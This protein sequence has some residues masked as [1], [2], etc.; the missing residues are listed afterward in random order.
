MEEVEQICS[1]IAIMDKGKVIAT[2]TTSELKGMIK[3]GEKITAELLRADTGSL[4]GLRQLAG[5]ASAEIV[6][7]KLIVKSE[8]GKNNLP[9][10][11]DYLNTHGVAYGKIYCELPTLNDVFL[12]ITGK[13]LRD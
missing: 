4:T 2:G 9:A 12:E 11:L 3:T 13:E 1:R 10:V 6:E 7:Q 8:H 5:I